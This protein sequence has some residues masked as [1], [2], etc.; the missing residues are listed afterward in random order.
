MFLSRFKLFFCIFSVLFGSSVVFSS[1]SLGQS[2]SSC[3]KYQDQFI[4]YYGDVYF[5]RG[6]KRFKLSRDQIYQ[7]TR[8]GI[9]VE[10]VDGSV[11]QSLPMAGTYREARKKIRSCRTLE[12]EYI[13]FSYTDIFWV[14]NCRKRQFL[15]WD[16][17]ER[18]YLKNHSSKETP[19]VLSLT[20]EEFTAIADGE[21]MDSIV[22]S[23]IAEAWQQA[24]PQFDILPVDEACR[25][26]EGKFVWYYSRVYKIERC[27]KRQMDASLFTKVYKDRTQNAVE[28]TSQ[29]WL[30]LPSGVP[31]HLVEK[32]VSPLDQ[33]PEAPKK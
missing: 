6:C 22:D 24:N 2:K 18:H 8:D 25:G 3:R 10:A 13:T 12:G 20:W 4:A 23:E 1:K 30:S 21:P 26:L 31:I 29:Q 16:S 7:K 33:K 32:S 14:R 19:E 17:F 5:V 9:R 11:I 27:K 15:D 28:L